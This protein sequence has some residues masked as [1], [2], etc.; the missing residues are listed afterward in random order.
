MKPVCQKRSSSV[1]RLGKVSCSG[2]QSGQR[3]IIR[4]LV[5]DSWQ[6]S[7]WFLWCQWQS[8]GKGQHGAIMYL[9]ALCRVLLN[10]IFNQQQNWVFKALHEEEKQ[11]LHSLLSLREEFTDMCALIVPFGPTSGGKVW[12]HTL[13]IHL[14]RGGSS[15]GEITGLCTHR[16]WL[17]H[18]WVGSLGP[19]LFCN[20]VKCFN[21]EISVH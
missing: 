11:I 9:I 2:M 18:T 7:Y 3:K 8:A 16:T 14:W 21:H 4:H 17:L 20:L 13:N 19:E 12:T 1:C 5:R 6:T 10:Q 15:Q